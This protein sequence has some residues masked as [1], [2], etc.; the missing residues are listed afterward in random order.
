MFYSDGR[1]S[2][3]RSVFEVWTKGQKDVFSY[4]S[5]LR[6]RYDSKKTYASLI[7][8]ALNI[9]IQS[10]KWIVNKFYW[11]KCKWWALILWCV[12]DSTNT[13]RRLPVINALF[14]HLC[15]C[16]WWKC[17]GGV[18][19]VNIFR[20]IEEH[21]FSSY[22]ML[23]GGVQFQPRAWVWRCVRCSFSPQGLREQ[24]FLVFLWRDLS[25]EQKGK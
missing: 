5:R 23:C 9:N 15:L 17:P 22:G 14:A 18:W 21:T 8:A 1:P 4:A 11:G 12:Y 13:G 7:I 2:S 19:T 20:V 25:A 6:V 10:S 3:K 16:L 24:V